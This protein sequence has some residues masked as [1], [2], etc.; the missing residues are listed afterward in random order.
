MVPRDEGLLP[1]V[2]TKDPLLVA[3]DPVWANLAKLSSLHVT[4]SKLS[5][6]LPDRAYALRHSSSSFWFA[7]TL[8]A[9]EL[10]ALAGPPPPRQSADRG[11]S[12]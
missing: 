7:V 10:S 1:K 9:R 3:P 8:L 2:P 4:N 5:S 11:Q 6:L 12:I